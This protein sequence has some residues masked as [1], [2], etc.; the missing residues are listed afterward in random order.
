M[1]VQVCWPGLVSHEACTIKLSVP[2]TQPQ[3]LFCRKVAL[4]LVADRFKH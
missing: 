2:Q 4:R 3:L 1:A